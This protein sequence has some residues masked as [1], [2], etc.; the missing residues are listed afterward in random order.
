M[1]PGDLVKINDRSTDRKAKG[2]VG[3][4]VRRSA[5]MFLV[6]L[7]KHGRRIRAFEH[8]LEVVAKLCIPDTNL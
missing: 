3:V 7:A 1:V 6:L 8:E 2:E 5:N 4:V